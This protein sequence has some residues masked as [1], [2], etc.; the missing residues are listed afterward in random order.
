MSEHQF[1]FS[2][3]IWPDHLSE[4][5]FF[6]FDATRAV[7]YTRVDERF[8]A[9]TDFRIRF[10]NAISALIANGAYSRLVNIHAD[11]THRMHTMRGMGQVGTLRFLPWHRSY[12]TKFEIELRLIDST[13]SIPYWNWLE[14][15]RIPDWLQD[16]LPTGVTDGRGRPI[17][18][19]RDPGNSRQPTL[20]QTTEMAA[21]EAQA[22]Y[23]DFT[24][25]LEGARPYGAHNQ[26][27]MWVGATMS[28]VPIAP[29]DP[30]FWMHHAFCD[31]IWH[32]WQQRFP[33][34][35]SNLT[36]RDSVLDPWPDTVRDVENIQSLGYDYA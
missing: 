21:V 34:L 31:R 36:G 19:T 8:T 26:V 20:P 13:L 32:V 2:D 27:H 35:S 1:L 11:M 15:P 18:V 25:G 14:N 10:K 12:L 9:G 6:A 4:V 30:I 28:N 17:A 3:N 23:L 29:A 7:L 33:G 24:L 22:T 16:F 5:D